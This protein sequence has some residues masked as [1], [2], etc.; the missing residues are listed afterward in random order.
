M[1][2]IA[3]NQSGRDEAAGKA[4]GWSAQGRSLE[5]FAAAQ[6]QP[7]SSWVVVGDSI[8]DLKMLQAVN[9]AG[10]LAIAFNANEYALPYSTMSLASTSLQDL[11]IALE[12]WGKGGRPE[13][14]N[15]VRE[16]EKG[17]GIGDRAH[18]HWLAGGKDLAPALE[19]HR[20]IRRLVREEAAKL[21]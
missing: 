5:Q 11:W 17:G 21:G 10:G 15:I 6:R 7:L 2:A 13:V 8:T 20:R 14:E 12:A 3:G 4:E 19:V 16:K 1:A 9:Q 18:L